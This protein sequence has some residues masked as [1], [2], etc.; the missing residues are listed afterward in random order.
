MFSRVFFVYQICIIIEFIIFMINSIPLGID[1]QSYSHKMTEKSFLNIH[2]K[3]LDRIFD[4]FFWD[5]V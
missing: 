2:F 4:I 5:S 1:I 3:P